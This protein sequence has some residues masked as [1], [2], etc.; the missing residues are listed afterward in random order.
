MD[1]VATLLAVLLPRDESN[2]QRLPPLSLLSCAIR[3]GLGAGLYF[4]FLGWRSDVPL[5]WLKN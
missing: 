2:E 1:S 5:D 3:C 4:P